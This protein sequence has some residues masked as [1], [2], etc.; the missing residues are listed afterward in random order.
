MKTP[1]KIVQRFILCLALLLSFG[2]AFSQ[3]G[4]NVYYGHLHNHSNVSDGTG[5]PDNAYDYAKNTAGLDFFGLSDH[6]SAINTTEWATLKTAADNYNEDGVFTS[7]RGFEWSHSTLG[8]V[9]IINTDDYCTASAVPTFPGLL[10][11]VS[12]RECAAFFNHPGRQNS[13]GQEFGQFADTP[14]D[15]FVGM[16]L[17]N[18]NDIYNVYYYNDGYYPNDGNLGFYDEALTNG[19]KIAAGG[20][21]DNHSGTW[22]TDNDYRLAVL[23]NNL[24]RDDLYNAMLEKR[25]FST[26]D[27]NIKMSFKINGSEMGSTVEG[28]I[29][30]S[31]QILVTDGDGEIFTEIELI[32]NGVV[33]NTWNPNVSNVN[34]AESVTISDGDYYYIRVTQADNDEAISSA[35]F[36]SGGLINT[37]PV[38]SVSSPKN[39]THFNATQTIIISADA[40]DSDGSI[41]QVEFF[42][43]GSSIGIDNTSPY[44]VDWTVPTAGAY[45][46]TAK[47]T[48]NVG[49]FTNANPV[50]ITVG[51]FTELVSSQINSGNDDVE[52]SDAGVMYLTSTDIELVY[53]SYN[54]AGNQTVGLRFTDLG[55]PQGVT[56]TSASIQFTVDEISTDASVLTIFGHNIDDSPGFTASAFNVSQRNKTTASVNWSPPA[57]N[58]VNVYGADQQTPDLSSIIQEI[59]DLPGFSTSSAISLIV[60]GTGTRIAEAYEGVPAAA[61][62]LYVEYTNGANNP[63][64][65]VSDPIVEAAA[66]EDSPYSSTI[67]D[68]ASDEDGDDLLFSKV[69]GPTWLI[70]NGDG[71]LS[72]TPTNGDIELNSWIIQVSDGKGGT[73]QATLQITVL[74]TNDAP[75][76]DSDPIIEADASKDTAYFGSIAD[77][78]SDEDLDELTFSKVSGPTWLTAAAN[79]SLTGTP[80]S[81]DVGLNSWTVQVI[82]GKGETDQATL[83][84]TVI[85]P[86]DVNYCESHGNAVNEW[87]DVVNIESQLKESDSS[88]ELGY[89]DFTDVSFS[90]IAGTSYNLTLAPGFSPRSKFEYWKVWIDFNKDGDFDDAGEQVFSAD[91]QKSSVSGSIT[92]PEMSPLA[93]TMRVS[94]KRGAA[95]TSCEIFALGEVEDYTVVITGNDPQPP[96]ANFSANP[97]TVEVG[98]SVQFT[99][100]STNNPTS[101]SWTFAGGTPSTSTSQNPSVEYNAAGTYSVALT[102]TNNVGSDQIVRTGYVTVTD[103]VPQGPVA[104]FTADITKITEGESVQFTDQST[105][106][107]T[108][109]SW[110]FAGGIPSTSTSENPSVVYNNAGPYDVTL[111]VTNGDGNDTETKTA[112][113]VVFPPASEYCT[114][115]GLSTSLEWINIVN[116]EGFSNISGVNSGYGDF[117]GTMINL[118][119][120]SSPSITLTPGFSGKSQRE[121]WRVWIDFN[122]DNDF[123]DS[124]ELVFS[125]DNSK[126]AVGGVINI[127]S[128]VVGTT[129]MRISM[130]L[131]S[132]P[133]PCGDFSRGE[134]EDYTVD[135]GSVP[136]NKSATILASAPVTIEKTNEITFNVYPNPTSD[137]LY[138]HFVG[139]EGVKE[140]RLFDMTGR[141]IFVKTTTDRIYEIDV[142]SYPTGIYL[143]DVNNGINRE[144][145]KIRIK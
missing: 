119:P 31:I 117:T 76:F 14:S 84:I 7:F 116:I 13:T 125:E 121:F 93:T 52:E 9:T 71:S 95:P 16:E 67:M 104:N 21:S 123:E 90:L 41:S 102:V 139:R 69:S 47:A 57:W 98:Q 19:W 55:I 53:D 40:T 94:M 81:S 63:P 124:G 133:V 112:Y 18:K 62:K 66:T 25:F 35:V 127:P 32:K 138:V 128:D 92:I 75:V 26:L 4:Y 23:A 24:T 54:T 51:T 89:E 45:I 109:W 64:I 39:G 2:I 46:I 48:D 134:V 99:D 145:R 22:G 130:K 72:G 68:D 15:K 82:D 97:I 126:S 140:I 131:G 86:S 78:A 107:P 43:N 1:T 100:H 20:S 132:V 60:T 141:T 6:A 38:C 91:K 10:S 88:G 103:V 115:R 61:A 110:S 58:T 122:G 12:T 143:I 5:T 135:F 80:G 137:K 87:I 79:G 44:S 74:N 111:T 11:W 108:T 144:N 37:P 33:F 73:A 34:I 114:S 96:V 83:E 129:R 3:S 136:S 49:A 8:H 59:V 120:G 77:N 70:V 105:N 118:T 65:F 106:N 113:I 50:N 85:D 101:W 28:G 36:V 29:N 56:V 27:N 30:K 142:S 17:W 42:V